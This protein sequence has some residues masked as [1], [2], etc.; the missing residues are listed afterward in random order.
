MQKYCM[1][2]IGLLLWSGANATNYFIDSAK[3]NNNYN[4][5]SVAR[6]FKTIQ[7]AANLTNPG[8]TVFIMNGSYAPFSIPRPGNA[9]HQ[10]VYTNY[11][12]HKPKI[13][14][15][16][17]T[18]SAVSVSAGSN[19]VTVN[20][21][22]VIGW[23]VNLS[24]ATDTITA[25]AALVCPVV[26]SP[27]TSTTY[28]PKYNGSGINVSSK[29]STIITHHVVISNN[30]VHDC[31]NVGIGFG[32]CDYITVQGNIT[33]NN[34]WYSPYGTSG[35]SFGN[36]ANYDTNTTTY[37]NIVRNN[38]SYS[39]RMYVPFYNDCKITDGN[40]IILDIPKAD[41]NGRSLVA[42]NICFNNGGSGIHTF[43]TNNVDIFN[44]VSY[45]NSAS[46]EINSSNIY[47]LQ[48][49]N[50]RIMNN[51]IV[52]RPGKKMNGI[53]ATTNLVYDY[54][55]FYGGATYELVGAHSFIQDPKFVN[56]STDPA[57]ADFRLQANSIG[58]NTGDNSNTTATDFA[59]A[60]RPIAGT[61]DIGAYE[62]NYTGTFQ[63][64]TGSSAGTSSLV[65]SNGNGNGLG[66][67]SASYVYGL[68]DSRP[69]VANQKSRKAFVY[70]QPLLTSIPA[71]TIIKSLKFRRAIQ[72]SS[73]NTTPSTDIVPVNSGL[74]VYLRNEAADN[75]G[76]SAFDWSSILPESS[77]NPATLVFGG[78]AG[79]V[80]GNAGGWKEL[81]FQTPFTYTG[82]NLSVYVEYFQSGNIAGGLDINWIYDHPSTQPLYNTNN[83]PNA[84]YGFRSTSTSGKTVVSGILTTTNERRPVIT[85]NYCTNILPISFVSF[86]AKFKNGRVLLNWSTANEISNAGFEVQRSADD[87]NFQSIGYV[88]AKDTN[89]IDGN[90]YNFTDLAPLNGSGY[91]RLLQKDRD[92]KA[93]YSTIVSI[94]N[95]PESLSPL[96]IYPNPIGNIL[97]AVINIP[98]SN[99]VAK[100][101]ICDVAG[102]VVSSFERVLRSGKNSIAIDVSKQ[103]AAT[104]LLVVEMPNGNRLVSKFL[105]KNKTK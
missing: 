14:S 25:K 74:R 8:D 85:I 20:G 87:G 9:T 5:L 99:I 80:I 22:E 70:P 15:T 73:S 51:I 97:Y 83:Y 18:Y 6:A 65:I 59:S 66:E 29:K 50:I 38:I 69:S 86:D 105:K 72:T 27:A 55:I 16:S 42:N 101:S 3:G 47:A 4:G 52:A 13:V 1:V 57:I 91:Y 96:R 21:L 90:A 28:I 36:S 71:N 32:N 10:I 104:Y 24:L 93:I 39:N 7:K 37:R 46:P 95:S 78:E 77:I 92:G 75:L 82:K 81:V 11:P 63:A 43:S 84:A 12:V 103:G 88:A 89:G 102:K 76:A 49:K 62:S 19:Y 30:I 40:G 58:I 56:P 54:N 31:C 33:Y 61:V 2:V 35:I 26:G 44:N 41:Y 64:C 98:E 94:S 100:I 17:T 79:N 45:L 48:A 53:N 67:V 68:C 34:S 60:A 23:G